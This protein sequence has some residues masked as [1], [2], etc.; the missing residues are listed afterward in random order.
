MASSASEQNAGSAAP[1]PPSCPPDPTSGEYLI[2]GALAGLISESLLHPIDTISHRA[3]VHPSSAYG[4]FTGAVRLI[5]VQE[6]VR[7]YFAGLS[8]TI[9]ASPPATAVYFWTYEWAKR[10]GFSLTGGKYETAVFFT[11]GAVSELASSV[12]FVPLEVVKSRLQLGANPARATGGT[13]QDSVNFRGISH[14]LRGIYREGGWPALMVGWKSGLIQDMCF[15]AT[16]FLLYENLKQIMAEGRPMRTHETL[17]AGCISGGIAA[18]VTNPLD[19]ITSRLMVQDFR[20]RSYGHDMTSVFKTTVA[21]GP[22]GLWRGTLPRVA[23]IAPL[24]ALAFAVYE[25]MRTYLADTALFRGS[26]AAAVHEPLR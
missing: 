17:L 19:V 4:G 16:Q 20:R 6:G 1:V 23:Q 8:A 13:L 3:K 10:V 26:P 5:Y 24:S 12:L 15:S 2:A 22:I 14:A 25:G 7:G 21:E 18:A 9:V 11:A